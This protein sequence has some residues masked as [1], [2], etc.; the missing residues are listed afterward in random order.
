M[1]SVYI[2]IRGLFEKRTITID[3]NSKS[4]FNYLR[5]IHHTMRGRFFTFEGID[6]SGKTTISRMVYEEVREKWNAVWTKE[7]TD[8]WLGK[9]VERAVEEGRDAATVALLFAADRKEHLKDIN[10]WLDEGK[11][12]ICDRYADSTI[13]YQ[14]VNLSGTDE[15]VKWLEELHLPF[16]VEPDITFLFV[17]DPSTAI[18][19]LEGRN[20]SPFEKIS[21]LE[22][23]QE[24][25]LRIAEGSKRFIKLDATE[26]REK[27][28]ERCLKIM[29]REMGYNQE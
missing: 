17:I 18:N 14:A 2:L 7:P 26:S 10:K 3:F 29:E 1:N 28:K 24:N 9:S 12:V 15:P 23:V 27:L 4:K 22:K 20:L 13:A 5:F 19:R 11:T 21:F 25:Y 8:G 16:Y 6:G